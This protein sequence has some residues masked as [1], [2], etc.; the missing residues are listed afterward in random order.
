MLA[1]ARQSGDHRREASA[2]NDLAVICLNQKQAPRAAALLEEALALTRGDGDPFLEG[3]VRRNLGLAALG[4]HQPERAREILEGAVAFARSCR[5]RFGEKTALDRLGS[6]FAKLNDPNRTIGCYERALALAREVGDRKH[7]AD[8][9]W[10]IA[11]QHADLGR[12]DEAVVKG[13][14]AVGLLAA[15]NS[16]HAAWFAANLNKYRIGEP[17]VVLAPRS[18]LSDGQG[19]IVSGWAPPPSVAEGPGQATGP[20]VLRM[21]FSAARSMTRFLGSGLKTAPAEVQSQRLQAC[22]GCAHHTGL[23]CRVCGCFTNVK[24]RMDHESCPLGHW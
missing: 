11:M 20:A 5:D 10:Q 16:P 13:E 17:S 15:M 21:A 22:A 12:K 3:D 18:A 4:V 9:L 6:A 8:L 23:R 14:E 2:L 24:T 7:E 1:A 19:V